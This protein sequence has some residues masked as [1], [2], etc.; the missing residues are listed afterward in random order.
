VGL[1]VLGGVASSRAATAEA[2]VSRLGFE[3]VDAVSKKELAAHMLTTP[4]SWKLWQTPPSFDEDGLRGDLERIE[5]FYRAHG[6]YESRASYTLD[7]NRR[8]TRVSVVIVVEEGEPVRLGEM[9]IDT[10]VLEALL[11]PERDTLLDDLPLGVGDVLDAERYRAAKEA[12]LLRLANRGYAR[13]SL[14]G[15]AELDLAARTAKLVWEVVPGP[16]VILGPI[17]IEGLQR[18]D[19]VLVRKELTLQ[20]GELYSR[21]RLRANERALGDTALFRS[22]IVEAHPPE[23]AVS[24]AEG[25]QTWPVTVRL[26]ERPP[27][28]IGVGVGWGTEDRFRGRVEWLHRNFTGHRRKLRIAAKYSSLVAG[29][30]A[31]FSQPRF[32]TPRLDFSLEPSLLRE[33]V[34]AFDANRA[35]LRTGFRPPVVGRWRGR[36]GHHFEYVDV[37][38]VNAAPSTAEGD[39][40]LS[41][42]ELGL[43][44]RTVD[45]AIDA[46]R[47]TRL[48]IGLDPSLSA[49]GSQV[50]FLRFRTEARGYLPV[51]RSVIALRGLWSSVAPFA[52][53][54]F[55]DVPITQRL[56]GGGSNSVRGFPYQKLGTLNPF[57]DPI[58]GLSLA[59][60]SAELRF[61]I[62]WH[63]GGVTFFDT[64]QVTTRS[65]ALGKFRYSTGVGLRVDTPIGPIRVDWGYILNPPPS[66]DRWRI[67]LSVGQAF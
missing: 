49:L 35:V 64:G 65:W 56:F 61:P 1:V 28:S 52:G 4:R 47:G 50:D 45:R 26:R 25:E 23:Q 53:D 30:G 38:K 46:K 5:S 34:P 54:G 29:V 3:G 9:R 39:A 31:R 15:G 62:W 60:A 16:R 66:I 33:T 27:R 36:L 42:L 24:T 51:W 41:I 13:A 40:R 10:S 67:H 48:E 63:I 7:W 59:E 11:V 12:L 14:R 55:A 21:D 20:P 37:T 19:P 8:R 22:I 32:F 44:R 43:S 57:G 6:Y 18:I 17:G 58:G 2:T